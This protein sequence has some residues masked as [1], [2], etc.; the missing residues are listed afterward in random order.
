MI[1]FIE[2]INFKHNFLLW[3]INKDDPIEY[4]KKIIINWISS[5]ITKY[6]TYK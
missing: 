1:K 3:L 5:L 2:Y 6:I 4:D